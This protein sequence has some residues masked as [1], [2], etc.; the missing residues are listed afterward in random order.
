MYH[1]ISEIK[2]KCRARKSGSREFSI[3]CIKI[4]ETSNSCSI[5]GDERTETIIAGA[6]KI[7]RL[8]KGINRNRSARRIT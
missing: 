2:I 7:P 5:I 4:I 1:L 8:L 3:R 6:N